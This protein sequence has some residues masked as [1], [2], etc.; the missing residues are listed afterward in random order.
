MNSITRRLVVVTFMA[1]TFLA[2]AVTLGYAQIARPSSRSSAKPAADTDTGKSDDQKALEAAKAKTPTP[3][4]T[5]VDANDYKALTIVGELPAKFEAGR[6]MSVKLRAVGGKSPYE[7]RFE[8]PVNNAISIPY[9]FHASADDETYANVEFALWVPRVEGEYQ[10]TIKMKDAAAYA[11]NNKPWVTKTFDITLTPFI[12]TPSDIYL[13]ADKAQEDVSK[14]YGEVNSMSWTAKNELQKSR[15]EIRAELGAAER[16]FNT[17]IN[18]QI[19]G[20]KK[21]VNDRIANATSWGKILTV[22]VLFIILTTLS[23]IG[24][25]MLSR[26]IGRR[27]PELFVIII[28]I[29]SLLGHA[30][31]ASAQTAKAKTA[32]VKVTAISP[33][34]VGQA[35]VTPDKQVQRIVLSA[36]V[37]GD[38]VVSFS[39]I[40]DDT[41]ADVSSIQF[42]DVKAKGNV[43]EGQLSVADIVRVGTYK[44]WVN[45]A[46]GNDLASGGELYVFNADMQ[47]LGYY[48]Q[49]HQSAAIAGLRKQLNDQRNEHAAAGYATQ[50][51]VNDRLK[52]LATVDSVSQVANQVKT[53]IGAVTHVETVVDAIQDVQNE[54]AERLDLLAHNQ[55]ELATAVNEV[56]RTEVKTSI[57]GGKHPISPDAA[58]RTEEILA[59]LAQTGKLAK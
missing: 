30:N 28:A 51:Y 35:Y 56:A 1:L 57:F 31:T 38:V 20:A 10:V 4:A 50:A 34:A 16:R 27:F 11:D 29:G 6:R 15:K 43:L 52:G 25:T 33:D 24:G 40:D 41:N 5:K 23:V 3:A 45:D 7:W 22:A 13:R 49:Q 42:T 37:K 32:A 48:I 14:L 54:H 53:A 21:E 44:V 12:P 58:R 9:A 47:L 26:K 8:G 36:P 18:S 46:D 39:D 19:A 2:L 59:Q 17:V 55:G